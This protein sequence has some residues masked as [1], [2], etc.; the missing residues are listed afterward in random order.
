MNPSRIWP[1]VVL[2][3]LTAC[4]KS[5]PAGGASTG[6]NP[7]TA[8]LDYIAAQG[9]A[10]KFAEKT[11]NLVEINAAVQKFQA[12]EDRYPRDF[13][14]LVKEHYLR[15]IPVAPPGMQLVYD[16]TSG[17]VRLVREDALAPAPAAVA[18]TSVAPRRGPGG[19]RIPQQGA[20]PVGE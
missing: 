17:S 3:S 8:P 14:E 4:K 6:N 9:R 1:L 11:I 13:N 7:M 20:S 12:M 18:P 15:E 5:D 10:K 19:I 16:R 2:L